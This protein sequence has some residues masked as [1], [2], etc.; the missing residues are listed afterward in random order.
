MRDLI[1]CPDPVWISIV[2]MQSTPSI[3]SMICGH[4]IPD[5]DRAGRT[6]SMTEFKSANLFFKKGFSD[7]LIAGS[8]CD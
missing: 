8:I 5:A 1:H 3:L 7:P 2:T 6:T 4:A